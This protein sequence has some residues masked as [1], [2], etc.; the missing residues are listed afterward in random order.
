MGNDLVYS[1]VELKWKE[2]C[3]DDY[4]V[5]MEIMMVMVKVKKLR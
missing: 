4:L 5:V 3:D 2:M 1:Q